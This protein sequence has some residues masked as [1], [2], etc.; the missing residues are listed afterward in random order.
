MI[1]TVA[2][3]KA[4]EVA[5][6]FAS[7]QITNFEFENNMPSTKDSAIWAIEDT[8]WCF[9]DDFKEHKI[10]DNWEVPSEIKA[11]MARWLMFLYS[12]EEYLW[13]KISYPGIRPIEYGF[14]GKLFKKH[15]KQQAFLNAGNYSVWPFINQESYE[16]AKIN[17]V[18]LACS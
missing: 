8:I 1:D 4:A 12:N 5:R 10:N 18:L 16:N 14:F 15:K 9:Y 7:G 3:K 11:M 13:P 6:H 2:R 17:P